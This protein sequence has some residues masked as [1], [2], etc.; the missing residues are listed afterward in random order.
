MGLNKAG[1]DRNKPMMACYSQEAGLKL[2]KMFNSFRD[3]AMVYQTSVTL[4]PLFLLKATISIYNGS[5]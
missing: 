2:S 5:G 4:L 3:E 1:K